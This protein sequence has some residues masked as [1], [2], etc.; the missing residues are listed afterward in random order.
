MPDIYQVLNKCQLLKKKY[1]RIFTHLLFALSLCEPIY[2]LVALTIEP[3][4]D[5]V[6]WKCMGRKMRWEE[7]RETD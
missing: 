3:N 2:T 1:K 4:C 5:T 6:C 7:K